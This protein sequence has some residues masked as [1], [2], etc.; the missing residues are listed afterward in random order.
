MDD[1]LRAPDY[2]ASAAAS[3]YRTAAHELKLL[4]G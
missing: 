2:I 1:V 3:L 4:G